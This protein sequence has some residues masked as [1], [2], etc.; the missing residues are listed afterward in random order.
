[1]TTGPQH[2]E[3][4]ETTA[5]RRG[6]GGCEGDVLEGRD[7]PLGGMSVAVGVVPRRHRE[8]GVGVVEEGCRMGHDRVD[9]GPDQPERARVDAFLALG[10][11]AHD[12][13]RRAERG[14]LLLDAA[15]VGDREVGPLEQ[16]GEGG[17][18]HGT[19]E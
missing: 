1:M 10:L 13:Y 18:L 6:L 8:V 9:V 2:R 7:D 17:V 12:E 11:L 14:C 19:H 15:G 4:V 16:A 3:P 5:E